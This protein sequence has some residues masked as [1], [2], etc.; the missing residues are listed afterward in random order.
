[1]L[2]YLFSCRS[3]RK[4]IWQFSLVANRLLVAA[5]GVSFLLVFLGVY[6]PVLQTLL[7]TVSITLLDWMVVAIKGFL[8]LVGIE[9]IKWHWIVKQQKE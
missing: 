6:A 7:G 3:L 2:L 1:S 9:F 5:A 8:V 4:N